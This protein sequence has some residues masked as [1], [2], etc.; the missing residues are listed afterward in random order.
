LSE[1]LIDLPTSVTDELGCERNLQPGF[2]L[3]RQHGSL[4]PERR[5]VS[6]Q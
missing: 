1:V 2:I 4:L 6:W 3:S 5:W